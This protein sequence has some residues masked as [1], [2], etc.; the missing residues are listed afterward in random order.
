ML[1]LPSAGVRFTVEGTGL[2]D[3]D[4][5]LADGGD[6]TDAGSDVFNSFKLEVERDGAGEG[7]GGGKDGAGERDRD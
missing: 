5:V 2:S 4:E 3:G 7:E 6:C 1:P